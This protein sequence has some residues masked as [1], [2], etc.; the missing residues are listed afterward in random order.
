M[1]EAVLRTEAPSSHDEVAEALQSFAT[2]GLRVRFR[3]GGTKMDW[4]AVADE[5]DVELSFERLDRIVEHN[6]G[7]L[8]AILEAGVPLARA[9]ETFAEAGQMLAIDPPD[10]GGATIGGVL[11]TADSGPLRHRYAAPRDLVLGM[12]V[13]LTDGSVAS[14]G[15]KVIK[16]V[17]GYDLAKL[18]TGAYG[19]LGAILQVAVRLH[20]APPR[21]ATARAL[22]D[23][24]FALAQAARELAHARMEMQSLDVAWA[25]GRGALL[26]R[27][28][29]A[30][31]AAQAEEAL[32]PAG[33]A[34]LQTDLLEDD[35]DLWA[36]Q[37]AMQRSARAAVV[38]VS[39]VQTQLDDA[40]RTADRLGA[41]V[42]GRVALGL[43][44]LRI[45]D[46]TPE[47]IAELRSALSPSPCAVLDAPRELREQV[48]V[49]GREPTALMRRVRERF[50]PA[51][52]CNPGVLG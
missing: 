5:P 8:T 18:F 52:V 44:W 3:G 4:G 32:E 9:Q 25:G 31:A 39:G 17:A 42:V 34:G 13:A 33:R 20:P 47:Q 43:S 35:R 38:R 45:P 22:S 24:A 6:A 7:D 48:D 51:G 16:N 46:A 2:D 26:A 36:G 11:A 27:F 28:G 12:K 23:D 14:S 50:D 21:A 37:R 49:W 40:F 29:G 15:G 41:S 30:A 19:T 1:A 10:P